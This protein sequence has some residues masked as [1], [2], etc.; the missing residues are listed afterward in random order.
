MRRPTQNNE[1]PKKQIILNVEKKS[2]KMESNRESEKMH[3][4]I[5]KTASKDKILI[6]IYSLSKG[7]L[8][9]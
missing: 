5:R 7:E 8:R 2:G 9:F 6:L 3:N 4:S 1:E